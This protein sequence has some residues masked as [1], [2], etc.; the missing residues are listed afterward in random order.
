MLKGRVM[1]LIVLL[2]IAMVGL[3]IAYVT[4][5]IASSIHKPKRKSSNIP[6][7]ARSPAH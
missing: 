2:V 1:D 6:S 3:F 4:F 7:P 5:G